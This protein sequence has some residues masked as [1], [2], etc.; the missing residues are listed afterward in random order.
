MPK[1]G[2]QVIKPRQAL[3][4]CTSDEVNRKYSE[5]LENK[6]NKYNNYSTN[7]TREDIKTNRNAAKNQGNGIEKLVSLINYFRLLHRIL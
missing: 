3:I 5:S 6:E 7:S 2:S 4:D 1:K